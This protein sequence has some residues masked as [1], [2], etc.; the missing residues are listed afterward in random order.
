MGGREG[1]WAHESVN[2]RKC[3]CLNTS[4]KLAHWYANDRWDRTMHKARSVQDY[5]TNKGI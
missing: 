4:S 2:E 3:T 5:L 1:G